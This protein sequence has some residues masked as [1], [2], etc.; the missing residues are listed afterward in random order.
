MELISFF[1]SIIAIRYNI[2]TIVTV[3]IQWKNGIAIDCAMN[4]YLMDDLSPFNQFFFYFI[5]MKE[6]FI[7][8]CTKAMI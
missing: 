7:W 4:L 1:F 3:N 6:L 8:L 2:N 5:L